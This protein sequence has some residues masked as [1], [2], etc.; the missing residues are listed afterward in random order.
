M[1][2]GGFAVAGTR[3]H[4][5]E[6][7]ITEIRTDAGITSEFHWSSYR[8]GHRKE[9]AYRALVDYGFQLVREQKAAL[10]IIIAKFEGYNHKAQKGQNRDTSVNRMYYQLCL[11]RLAGFYGHARAIHVRLDAGNDCDDVCAMRNQLCADAYKR[12]RMPNRCRPNCIRTITPVKSEAS[13]IVQMA[14]VIIGGVASK[15][16]AINHSG[17]KGPLAEYILKAS[18]RPNWGQSTPSSE[19]RLTVW[20]HTSKVGT[21]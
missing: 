1:V 17:E 13:P 5:I 12:F 7:R 18:G 21:P 2:A 6:T 16:N 9:P 4:E 20:N 14:D 8:G 15:M 3:I 19:R 10:H 11:H